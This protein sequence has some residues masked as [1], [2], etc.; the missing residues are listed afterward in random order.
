MAATEQVNEQNLPTCENKCTSSGSELEVFED[1][2]RTTDFFSDLLKFIHTF[3]IF[4][5]FH[6]VF[7]I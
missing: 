6:H 5:L 4:S 7:A 2:R 3:G 1:T